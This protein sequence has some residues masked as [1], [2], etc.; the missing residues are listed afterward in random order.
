MYNVISQLDIT[1]AGL[2]KS[3]EI[4]GKF[5]CDLPIDKPR[6]KCYNGRLL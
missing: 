5:L 6:E 2:G 1:N 4:S 3:D